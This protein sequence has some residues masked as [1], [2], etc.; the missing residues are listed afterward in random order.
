LRKKNT[1]ETSRGKKHETFTEYRPEIEALLENG[2]TQRF[3][4]KP[5]DTTEANFHNWV[6]KH[7]LKRVKIA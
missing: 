4:A 2:S 7:G 1:G 3:I 5:Y 6:K